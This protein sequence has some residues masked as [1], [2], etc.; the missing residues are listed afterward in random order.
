VP[1]ELNLSSLKPAQ[2]RTARKRVGRGTGSGK[3]RY[4]GRG[5]KGQK[6]RSGSHKMPAG[7]EGGQ[8]RLFMRVPKLRGN[9]SKDAMP[10]GPFRTHTQ[11]VNV[12]DLERVFD[13]GTEVTPELLKAKRLIRTT[14]IDVKILGSGDLTK[15]LTVTAHSVSKSAREK[16]EGAGGTVTL[17]REPKERKRKR[18]K[19]TSPSAEAEAETQAVEDSGDA[20]D[21]PEAA[22]EPEPGEPEE[23]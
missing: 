1:A 15:K 8:T 14:R 7:F 5:I 12:R 21:E 4:S 19:K 11:G 6:S 22:A 13:A 3:G 20:P 23:E 9:T 18:H 10:I 17:L 16:I 2:K